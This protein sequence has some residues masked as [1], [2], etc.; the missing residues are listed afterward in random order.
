MMFSS[1]RRQNTPPPVSVVMPSLNQAAFLAAA[2][3]SVFEQG[4]EGLELVV[5]D[6]GSTDGSLTE[7][8]ALAVQFPG[9]LRWCSVPDDGP[10]QAVNRAVEWARG[11][12]IGWLNSDDLYAPG[13]V[14]RA[15]QHLAQSPDDVMVYGEAEHVDGAGTRIE[16]YPTRPPSTPLEAYAEG[17]HICQPSAFF[18]RDAFLALGGLDG[19]L[20]A[21]FDF[22]LWLR[23]FKAYPGRI[24]FVPELQARSRLHAGSITMRFRERVALEGMQVVH[25]H[26]GTAPGHWL[27]T[28]LE[29]LCT[30]HPFHAE[31]KD[32]D[33]ELQRLLLAAEP[34]MA[35]DGVLG[36][37][38]C[39]QADRRLQFAT[40]HFFA[41][42][43]EDGWAGA[44]LDLRLRQPQSPFAAI[45]LIGRHAAPGGRPLRLRVLAPDGEVQ[46]LEVDPGPFGWRLDLAEQRPGAQLLYRVNCPDAFVPA[47]W[48][49]GSQDRRSL[50]FLLDG[51]RL[52]PTGSA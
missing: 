49:P 13:A 20:R 32:L 7:L 1:W 6:G 48:E 42:V 30:A 25:R 41:S 14:Q 24:G 22:D 43:Y 15:L 28:H 44:T 40:P 31:R 52:V 46:A 9:Q 21:A 23:F 26:L 19:S 3:Q 4:V 39:L 37:R 17:C 18:R 2:V 50:A 36:L 5:V 33:A 35:A 16:A 29:E 27:L 10:A 38:Q 51:C 11:A 8:A 12:V 45:E 34:W 47:L